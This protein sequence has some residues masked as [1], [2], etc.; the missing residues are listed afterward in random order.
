ML[1]KEVAKV[2]L[3]SYIERSD[4][5]EHFFICT[6]GVTQSLRGLL[7]EADRA[8]IIGKAQEVI[9]GGDLHKLQKRVDQM[10]GNAELVVSSYVQ[11]LDRLVAWN[12]GEF[13]AALSPCWD[14][15]SNV[16]ER[17]FRVSTAVREHPRALFDRKAYL[18][19]CT[20]LTEVVMPLLEEGKLPT[21]LVESS[22]ADPGPENAPSRKKLLTV[23]ALAALA[24]GEVALVIAEG[25]AGKT[26]LLELVRAEVANTSPNSKLSVLIN[27]AEYQAGTLNSVVH[28]Q[29]GVKSGSWKM[30]PDDLQILCDGI[31]EAPPGVVKALFNE[32][33]PL[34]QSSLISCVF[35]SREDS[36]EVRTVLPTKPCASIRIAPLTPGRV[37]SLAQ[38]ELLNGT[39]VSAFTDA[40]LAMAR[41]A[42]GR[43]IWTPFAV[44]VA[45]KRWKE[46]GQLGS[47]LGELLDTIVF[48]RAER[49]LEIS[50]CESW[51][52]LPKSSVLQLAS[53]LAFQM[54]VVEGR[55]TCGVNE[56][57]SI[58]NKVKCICSNIYG[59]DGLN[60][61]Q[62]T[63][64]LRKHDLVQQSGDDSFKWSH[65]LVAGALA[66]PRLANNWKPYLEKLK[67]PLTDDVWVFAVRHILPSDLDE[68]LGELYH[69]DLML[70]ARATA[71]LPLCERDRSLRYIFKAIQPQ[72]PERLQVTG[73]YALAKVGTKRAL[74]FLRERAERLE[75]DDG[76]Q[77]ACALA[78]SGDRTY[79]LKLGARVDELRQAGWII[80]GGEVAIWEAASLA[81]RIAIAR[82]RLTLTKPGEAVNESLNLISCEATLDDIPLLESHLHAAKDFTAWITAL[83]AIKSGHH[84][85]CQ[86][87]FED[88]LIKEQGQAKAQIMT[89]GHMLGLTVDAED[90]FSLL[91]D[92]S[93]EECGES[94][95]IVAKNDLITKV[96]SELPMSIRI[97]EMIEGQ[98]PVS[99][100]EKKISLWNMAARV[101]SS[102]IALAALDVF[103]NDLKIVW[104]SANYFIA[105]QALRVSHKIE[106]QVA[107]D[108]YLKDKRNWFT[109]STY[110][111]FEL[112]EMLGFTTRSADV[113]QQMILRVVSIVESAEN[114]FIPDFDESESQLAQDFK[115]ESPRIH[116]MHFLCWL[117][118]GSVAAK[119]ILPSSV[120]LKF[121]H[122]DLLGNIPGAE[123]YGVFRDLDEVLIDD[124]LERVKDSWAQ[125]ASLSMVCEY[126]VTD[127]RLNLLRKYLKQ[128]CCHPM[129]LGYIKRALEKCW[130]FG[131]FE[132]VVETIAS[133]DTWPAE[134]QQ[135]FWDIVHLVNERVTGG[136]RALIEK[137]ICQ[138][139]TSF[140]RRILRIW[141]QETLDCRVGLSRLEQEN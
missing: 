110:R 56:I 105:H 37:R 67:Q 141:L 1:A 108:E 24:P 74:S 60:S 40:Y 81:D 83:R 99:T 129:A 5:G 84:D 98:L 75:E 123:I 137:Y 22:G 49:D 15:V 78:Y 93:L 114:G 46:S 125:R 117:V 14:L 90:T 94:S 11:E 6:G 72:Q 66:A 35:T 45:L 55:G 69:A 70:G 2:A 77:A 31:N 62:F 92:L 107:I 39:A 135:F 96:F 42:S 9:R 52:D 53:E 58:I 32:L 38:Y 118:P 124:E 21:G 112:Q 80:S 17:H 115:I 139:K 85:Y 138:A 95:Q 109:F 41:S 8:G 140:A 34:L 43:Y 28:S 59:T 113:L 101:E 88:A 102:K 18:E 50:T 133:L 19:R 33:K 20:N 126:G 29:L 104:C 122:F 111:V 44:R 25:G 127:R 16:L 71:E 86:Q 26:K 119:H 128:D 7:R 68:F 13:D 132:M 23:E 89:G 97:R 100:G 30:L 57:G 120:L 134:C 51:S 131:V 73:L 103:R 121:L 10:G 27:C 136:E 91:M 87:L 63:G 79:L 54:F 48:A 130:C 64:L 65:Q 36:R 4:V 47:T 76:F 3:T 61:H 116:L 106:L 12:M 82:E